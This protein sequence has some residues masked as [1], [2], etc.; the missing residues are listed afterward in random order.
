MPSWAAGDEVYGR[1]GPSRAFSQDNGIG[2]VM[3]GRVRLPTSSW[4]RAGG[5]APTRPWPATWPAASISGGGRSVRLP[6]P[7]GTRLR[8]GLAGYRQPAALPVDP[9]HLHTGELAFHYVPPGRPVTL[10]A[11]VRVACLRWPVEEDFEF[12]KDHFGLDH[13]QARLHTA[14]LRHIVLTLAA[15][16]VCAIT[17]SQAGTRAPAPILPVTPDA[18]PPEDPG[19]IAPA[20]AT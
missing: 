12:G 17:A 14:L 8:L 6:G 1:S 16:A 2:Y 9:Q 18:Q 13:S 5:W 20:V 3:R 7:R 4:Q 10:T 15:L 19:L 11:L